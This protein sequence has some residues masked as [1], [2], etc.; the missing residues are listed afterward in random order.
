[1][2][3]LQQARREAHPRL[4]ATIA[5]NRLLQRRFEG[6]GRYGTQYWTS[7][8]CWLV[9]EV[10]AT[11][12][13]DSWLAPLDR[14]ARMFRDGTGVDF[15]VER[16]TAAKLAGMG[17]DKIRFF[18]NGYSVPSPTDLTP[19]LTDRSYRGDLLFVTAPD[20]TTAQTTIPWR[21]QQSLSADDSRQLPYRVERFD[22][23]NLIV[24]VSN[25]EPMP[26]WMFY[27]D[28][29]HPWWRATVNGVPA[30]VYQANVAYKAVRVEPGENV[31]HLRFGSRLF[32]TLAALGAMNAG[33]WLFAVGA[34]IVGL[35]RRG[36]G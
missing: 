31:V 3:G 10:N 14:F 25:T 6:T 33:F 27:S 8:A 21:S 18:A 16:E 2:S 4:V 7:N 23:N 28:V 26:V 12:Q 29:W 20:A 5:F 35:M 11:F 24:H 34:M 9:D 1:V 13:A 22:A 15:P 32:G 36:G 17:T 19:I 30:A